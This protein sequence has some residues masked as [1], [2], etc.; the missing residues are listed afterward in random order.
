MAL[1]KNINLVFG[2][3][4]IYFKQSVIS[5]KFRIFSKSTLGVYL[6]S[7]SAT[8]FSLA[9]PIPYELKYIISLA[10]SKLI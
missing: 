6:F 1:F 2:P 5:C 9:D 3:N 4:L 7:G 10:K 8:N